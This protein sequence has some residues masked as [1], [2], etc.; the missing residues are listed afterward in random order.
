MSALV[1]YL[2][3]SVTGVGQHIDLS[4]NAA[5]NVTSE[6][7]TFFWLV[8]GQM[9]QRQTGRHAAPEPTM[10]V[11]VPAEDGRYVS[12]GF[13]P[14]EAKDYQALLGWLDELGI[15]DEFPAA[16][17]LE[18]GVE[19]GGVD[20]RDIGDDAE[21]MA[22]FGAGRE[23]LCFIASRIPSYD[24]FVGAQERDIQ[25][26]VV[27]A[28][29]EAFDDPHFRSRGFPVDVSHEELDRTVTYPGA[30]FR[31]SATPWRITRRPPLVGEH[32]SELGSSR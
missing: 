15:K 20:Y 28:P 21:A 17:F 7:G 30:P 3:R 10:E 12:T 14:S 18:R 2:H 32:N 27:Y 9:V 4:M 11:Q 24:F 29:D 23:A 22:I 26:G 13:P 25:C 31:L 5:A 16:F 19:R 6:S 1:A 8:A